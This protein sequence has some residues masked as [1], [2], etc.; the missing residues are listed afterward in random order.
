LW[1]KDEFK[2]AEAV[3]ILKKSLSESSGKSARVLFLF[4]GLMI[5]NIHSGSLIWAQTEALDSLN[6]SLNMTMD[7]EQRIR[8]LNLI[9]YEL[10]QSD[11]K[12]AEELA[13]EALELARKNENKEGIAFALTTKGYLFEGSDDFMQ[14]LNCYLEALTLRTETGNND[15]IAPLHY[16]IGSLY[17][18]LGDYQKAIESCVA[19]LKIYEA[20]G[21]KNGIAQIFRVMGSIYKY[22]G[23][24][25]KSLYYYFNGLTLNEDLGNMSGL[26]NSYNNIG[27]VYILMNEVDKALSYYHKSLDI[28]LAEGIE[29]EAAINYGNIGVAFLQ[30]DQMDSALFYIN[31]RYNLALELNDKKGTAISMGSFG[32]YYLKKKEY[33]TAIEYY[34]QALRQSRALGLLESAKGNLQSLSDLFEEKADYETASRYFKSYINLRDSL[35]NQETLQRIEQIEMEYEYEKE[36][37]EHEMIDQRNGFLR[38]V[39]FIALVFILLFLLIIYLIQNIKLKHKDLREK[40]LG[41]EKEQL[42]YEISFRDKELFS[43][44][45]Y[46]AE[47]NE[48]INDITRRL[49]RVISEPKEGVSIVKDIIRDL[50]FNSNVQTWE[51]FECTFLKVHPEF[52][53]TLVRRFPELS[54]NERRLCAFLRLNLS[55]KD[56]S[57]ITHQ[58]LP[59]LT[60]ARTRLRKK[61]GIANTGENLASFLSQI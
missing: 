9:A 29:S 42:Q 30:M 11:P 43:K 1:I 58:S 45:L 8:N 60:V 38:T 39:G 35:L 10:R 52:F 59:T 15:E 61:L 25:E 40:A 5:I 6:R 4:L 54:P 56:I 13:N 51:E 17:K 2:V 41:L 36:R 16:S 53:N 19:G 46:L 22:N 23:E 21:D 7:K 28:N 55:T 49:A 24:Y 48:L 57:N 44:A 50:K 31:K 33:P 32:D 3:D 12:K 37:N 34:K 18:T 26:A 20:T 14:A 27:V 47:K